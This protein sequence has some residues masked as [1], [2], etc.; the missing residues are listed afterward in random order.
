MKKRIASTN[1]AG[2][3]NTRKMSRQPING[4]RKYDSTPAATKPRGQKPSIKA[5]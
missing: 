4:R 1:S 5:M 2:I 3:A